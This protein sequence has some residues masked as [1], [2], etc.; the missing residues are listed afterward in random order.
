MNN[1]ILIIIIIALLAVIGWLVFVKMD[2]VKEEGIALG[3]AQVSSFVGQQL[4]EKGYLRVKI[5]QT[6]DGQGQFLILKPFRQDEE[7]K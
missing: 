2:Q 3:Q 1:K 5:G 6:E 7:T 4:K